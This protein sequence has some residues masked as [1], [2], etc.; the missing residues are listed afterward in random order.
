MS[1]VSNN[2]LKTINL[3]NTITAKTI[4]FRRLRREKKDLEQDGLQWIKI[5]EYNQIT[6]N[7]LTLEAELKDHTKDLRRIALNNEHLAVS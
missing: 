4:R 6:A 5:N 3:V 1:S 7:L 2:S